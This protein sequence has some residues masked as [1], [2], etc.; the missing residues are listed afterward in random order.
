[1]VSEY[2]SFYNFQPVGEELKKKII[3]VSTPHLLT[4]KFRIKLIIEKYNNLLNFIQKEFREYK[5]KK[6]PFFDENETYEKLKSF[7]IGI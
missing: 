7:S 1:M 5:F 4:L 2:K 6:D 3:E